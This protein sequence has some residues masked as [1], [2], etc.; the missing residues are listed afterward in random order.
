MKF[1]KQEEL[2][3]DSK[4]ELVLEELKLKYDEEAPVFR[5]SN[6]SSKQ[7]VRMFES[8]FKNIQNHKQSG[9]SVI[10]TMLAGEPGT[11]K[12]ARIKLLSKVLGLNLVV[13]E[14]PHLV[15]EHIINIP[16]LIFNTVTGQ[17]GHDIEVFMADSHLLSTLQKLSNKDS[18][19]VY[20]KKLYAQSDDV[21]SIYEQLGGTE[22]VIPKIIQTV[23]KQYSTILFLDEF[24]RKIN[25]RIRNMLRGILDGKIGNDPFP[26]D[27]YPIYATNV[28]DEGLD[29]I[30]KNVEFNQITLENPSK[31]E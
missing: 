29:D 19:A 30:P 2:Q 12:T 22:T 14:A 26:K 23:R 9:K 31:K 17:E 13:I 1:D 10:A 18:D 20:L 25:P 16:Y 3:E 8:I 15:E 11:G 27:V 24:L 21:I 4:K 28:E 5:A 7:T 6:T